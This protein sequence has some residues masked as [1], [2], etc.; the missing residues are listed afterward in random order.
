MAAIDQAMVSKMLNQTTPTGTSGIPA[1]SA[2]R[3]R[4]RR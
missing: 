1:R 2:P 3:C 4:P